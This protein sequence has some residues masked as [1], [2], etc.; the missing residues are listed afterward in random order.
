MTN[1]VEI[2]INDQILEI[3]LNKPKVNAINMDISRELGA[4]FVRL[5]DDPELA[6]AIITGAG[7]PIFSA[8]G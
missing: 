2:E 6:V 7:E 3:K 4:A 5:R 1:F 8:D